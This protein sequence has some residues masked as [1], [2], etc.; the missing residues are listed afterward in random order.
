M[1]L[2]NKLTFR[3]RIMEKLLGAKDTI[4]YRN[5]DSKGLEGSAITSSKS[6]RQL[7][8]SSPPSGQFNI[9]SDRIKNFNRAKLGDKMKTK[10]RVTPSSLSSPSS[11][12]STTSGSGVGAKKHVTGSKLSKGIRGNKKKTVTTSSSSSSSSEDADIPLISPPNKKGGI[13]KLGRSL[14]PKQN[15]EKVA[16]ASKEDEIQSTPSVSSA[17][18]SK[19]KSIVKK[20]LTIKKQAPVPG[21]T[22]SPPAPA[23]ASAS[24]FSNEST[25]G[26]VVEGSI[27]AAPPTTSE[28]K[29]EEKMPFIMPNFKKMKKSSTTGK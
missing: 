26:G 28:G 12:S 16:P 17:I 24:S 2:K 20:K 3:P 8:V 27:A 21:T 1:Q 29:N 13:P 5:L 7:S 11:P 25:E 19:T 9:A 14:N 22:T 4:L 23:A 15:K 6:K 18:Q 10:K